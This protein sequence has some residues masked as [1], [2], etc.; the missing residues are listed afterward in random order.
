MGSFGTQDKQTHLGNQLKKLGQAEMYGWDSVN[1]VWVRMAL[2]P[3]GEIIVTIDP[4]PGATVT[5]PDDT[6]VAIGATV[7]L[8]AIPPGTRKMIVQNSGPAGTWVRLR[9]VGA[10]PGA[11]LLM[12]RLGEQYYGGDGAL[13]ALEVE[14]VSFVVG[15][16][17]VATTITVQF[18]GD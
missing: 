2:S 8:P 6:V 3:G 5:T 13:D 18:Q 1:S 16:V 17:A 15:G 14:D 10:A 12:P 9:E 7:A 11:G 4:I